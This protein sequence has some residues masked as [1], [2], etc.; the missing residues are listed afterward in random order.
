M[1]CLKIMVH[2]SL[3]SVAMLD[4]Q[5]AV[6]FANTICLSLALMR[7]KRM[8]LSM[9]TYVCMTGLG[10]MEHIANNPISS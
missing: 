3:M 6:V 2:F 1:M 8:T 9:K 10:A 4:N 5:I 7:N